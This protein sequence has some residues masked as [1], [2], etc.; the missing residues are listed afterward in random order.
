M[1][2]GQRISL[3]HDCSSSARR[4]PVMHS[5][6]DVVCRVLP[7]CTGT[8]VR[9]KS[10]R[11]SAAAAEGAAEADRGT[12]EQIQRDDDVFRLGNV[13]VTANEANGLWLPAAA[14]YGLHAN[15]DGKGEPEQEQEQS[16][17]C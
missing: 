6:S 11:A 17:T 2:P 7:E 16:N 14:V 12:P 13:S 9:G 10:V 8:A 5:D 3:G 4:S 15:L 1:A